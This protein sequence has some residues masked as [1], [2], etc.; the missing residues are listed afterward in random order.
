MGLTPEWQFQG[1]GPIIDN[2]KG[3]SGSSHMQLGYRIP[4][5]SEGLWN[6]SSNPQQ[7]DLFKGNVYLQNTDHRVHFLN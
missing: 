1:V 4:D 5:S 3:S 7:T 2:L 6:I